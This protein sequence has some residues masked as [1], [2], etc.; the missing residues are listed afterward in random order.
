VQQRLAIA[1]DALL[2][3]PAQLGLVGLAY[4]IARLVVEGG[5]QEE[6]FVGEP[7]GL[8]GFAYDA[9]AECDQ[10]LTFR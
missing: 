8:A 9:L 5:V 3:G 2:K 6:P 4:K 10:L 1:P 7:K